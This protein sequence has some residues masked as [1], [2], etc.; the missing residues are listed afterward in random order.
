M[1]SAKLT[2]LKTFDAGHD[3]YVEYYADGT[4]KNKV[5]YKG[6]IKI[7]ATNSEYKVTVDNNKTHF[8]T[9]LPLDAAYRNTFGFISEH[10]DHNCEKIGYNKFYNV[11]VK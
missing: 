5:S 4:T 8:S 1:E 11:V 3:K 2:L 10:Y 9:F 6:S 7:E